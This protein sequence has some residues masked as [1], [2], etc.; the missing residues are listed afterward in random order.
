M[1]LP[2]RTQ[3]NI[4]A[5]SDRIGPDRTKTD[6]RKYSDRNG[7]DRTKTDSYS[8]LIGPD[9]NQTDKEIPEP[10]RTGSDQTGLKKISES[11]RTEFDQI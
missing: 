1:L 3:E 11:G 10:D 2:E 4:R 8:D 9:L 5:A 7:R 6:S